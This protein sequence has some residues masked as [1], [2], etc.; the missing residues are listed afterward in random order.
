ME[1]RLIAALAESVAGGQVNVSVL[2]REI[3]IS[4]KHYYELR[5]RFIDGGAEAV[6]VGKSRRPRHS[7]GRLAPGIEE[8]IVRWRKDLIENGWSAGP[9]TI[10]THLGREGLDPLPATST[11]HNV[12]RR[13]GL[14]DAQPH[15]RP[16]SAMV[17]FE[18]DAPNACWQLDGMETK[19]ADG[20]MAC[21]L[22]VTDDHSRKTMNMLAAAGETT[23]AAW[24]CTQAAIVMHGPP[25]RML[26][27]RGNALNGH[28]TRQSEFRRRLRLRG[29]QPISSR[30]Y[31]PQTCGKNERSHQDVITWLAARPAARTLEELQTLIDEYTELFNSWRPHQS[32]GDL[33][34]D[35]RYNARP[36]AGPIGAV[37]PERCTV[38]TV[39]V[40]SRGEIRSG[41]TSIQLGRCWQGATV[42]VMRDDLNVVI[43]SNHEVIRR[44]VIDPTKRY[45]GNGRPHPRGPKPHPRR[46]LPM[47]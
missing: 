20:T 11:I 41:G 21:I 42:T 1:T 47:S 2:C 26:T 39:R 24:E 32:I 45:Q 28:P 4:R 10:R 15:K 23:E 40:S 25:A 6:L 33:T 31:H 5:R 36:K 18:Y 9:R 44:L 16:R 34:P 3:G 12:L 46:V 19:L 38:T 35:Q 7:P 37:E 14:V 29:I 22:C 8:R 43:L 27:D 17:R 13:H 30:G